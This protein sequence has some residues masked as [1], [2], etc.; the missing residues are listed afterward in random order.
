MTFLDVA[1]EYGDPIAIS[2]DRYEEAR[3]K[4]DP[5]SLSF[6][7][8]CPGRSLLPIGGRQP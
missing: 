5:E 8:L 1:K 6:P 3:E 7:V 2:K 4:L